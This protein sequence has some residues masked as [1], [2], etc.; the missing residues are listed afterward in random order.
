MSNRQLK[1]HEIKNKRNNFPLVLLC[2]GIRTPENIGM[3][4]RVAEAFGVQK[5]IFTKYS[6]DTK[7]IKVKKTSR[8]T[9]KKLDSIWIDHLKDEILNLKKKKF[10]IL[11]LEITNHSIPIQNVYFNKFENIA[12]IIGSERYGISQEI[13]NLIDHYI[14]IPMVGKNSSMNVVNA[15]SIALYEI[16]KQKKNF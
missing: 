6:P 9:F 5:I 12:L 2:D 7:N 16:S 3:I 8:N 11:G 10:S 14:E 15:L 1:H 4:F 13:L